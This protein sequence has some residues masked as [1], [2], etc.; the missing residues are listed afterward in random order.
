[1]AAAGAAQPLRGRARPGPRSERWLADTPSA[2][3]ASRRA[4][5]GSRCG[6]PAGRY[7]RSAAANDVRA[8]RERC[9]SNTLRCHAPQPRHAQR[10]PQPPPNLRPAPRS[11][12]RPQL[13]Q[14]RLRRRGLIRGSSPHVALWPVVSASRT[15]SQHTRRVAAL[16]RVVGESSRRTSRH[17]GSPNGISIARRAEQ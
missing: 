17:L 2:A 7:S 9:A 10:A 13:R 4:P 11:A 3:R 5:A 12:I 14:Q 16:L 1:M 6:C 8:M 15:A